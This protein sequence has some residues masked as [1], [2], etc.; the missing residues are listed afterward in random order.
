M[1]GTTRPT[2]ISSGRIVEEEKGA[3][4][5]QTDR[6]APAPDRDDLVQ[7]PVALGRGMDG[8]FARSPP[9]R[10]RSHH[11]GVRQGLSLCVPRFRVVCPFEDERRYDPGRLFGLAPENR[12]QNWRLRLLLHSR[13]LFPPGQIRKYE[14][15][16]VTG[17]GL[18]PA[19]EVRRPGPAVLPRPLRRQRHGRKGR[20]LPTAAAPRTSP[21]RRRAAAASPAGKVS[22]CRRGTP[23]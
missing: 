20:R 12:H 21:V 23:P 8:G 16:P 9:L 14:K 19:A 1:S 3:E 18:P 6:M 11:A 4:Q 13:T 15:T 22:P 7:P 17:E 5:V 2:T 10:Q